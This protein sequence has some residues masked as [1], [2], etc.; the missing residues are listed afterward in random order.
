LNVAVGH[1]SDTALPWE[2]GNSAFAAHRDTFFRPLKDIKAGDL[3]RVATPRGLFEYR[4]RQT[5]IVNPEDVW[6]LNA[7]DQQVLTL[8]TCYPFSYIGHAPQRFVVRAE[9]IDTPRSNLSDELEAAL[10]LRSQ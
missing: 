3:V 5:T 7:T 4:V 10:R 6:V 1:L 9:R 2:P 8:I